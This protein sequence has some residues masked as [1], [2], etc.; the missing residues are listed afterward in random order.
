MPRTVGVLIFPQFQLLDA[1]GPIAVFEV[2]G[3]ETMPAPYRLRV[4]AR[5]AGPV[6]AG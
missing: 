1:T 6:G 3:R 5:V 2:A 4:M